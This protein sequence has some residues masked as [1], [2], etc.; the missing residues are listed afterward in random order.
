MMA[1]LRTVAAVALMVMVG[2][3]ASAHE[4]HDH[5]PLAG[6][7][8]FKQNTLHVHASFVSAPLVGQEAR[9]VLEAKDPETHQSVGLKDD[10][11]VLLWM[12]TMGHGSA[13]TQVERAMD[14]TG[15]ILPGTFMVRNIFFVMGGEWE[16]RVTLTDAQGVKETKS[17]VV[18]IE[19]GHD[20]GS[21]HH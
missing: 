17:F 2:T 15:N 9:M 20:H 16:I 19:G 7:L 6:H 1:I 3:L 11:E 4:G 13:P 18:L 5:P 8:S 14:A 12:P 21:G 10:V